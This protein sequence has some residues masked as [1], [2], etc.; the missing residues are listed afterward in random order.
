VA[1]TRCRLFLS[2]L[3]DAWREILEKLGVD[4]NSTGDS[5]LAAFATVM[6]N[7]NIYIFI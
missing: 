6:F 1:T 2:G 5:H 4:T 7:L 3:P